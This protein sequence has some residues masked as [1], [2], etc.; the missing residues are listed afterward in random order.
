MKILLLEDDIALNKSI[1]DALVYSGYSVDTFFDGN[2]V[3][4]NLSSIYDLYIMDINVP[5]ISGLELL[6]LIHNQN[7]QSKIIMISANTDINIIENAYNLGCIDYLKKPFHLKELRIKIDMFFS[8]TNSQLKEIKLKP[9]STLSKKE[10]RF[11]TLLLNNKNQGTT[12][13][14]IDEFVYEDKT[15][16]NDGIRALVKRLRGKLEDDIIKNL[17]DEGYTIK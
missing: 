13:Q 4:D 1:Y 8:N 16:T 10:K 6:N 11:L 14:M 3:I 17:P 5:N 7:N 9:D 15:M 2:D 12:Y